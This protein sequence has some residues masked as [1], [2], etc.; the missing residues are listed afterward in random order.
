MNKHCAECGARCNPIGNC[1]ISA[2]HDAESGGFH[3]PSCGRQQKPSHREGDD[4]RACEG[5]N[6]PPDDRLVKYA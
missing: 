6:G 4:C 3:C 1:S 2:E 5:E